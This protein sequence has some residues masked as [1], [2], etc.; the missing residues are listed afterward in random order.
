[1]KT[2]RRGRKNQKT[3]FRHGIYLYLARLK[4]VLDA[5]LETLA[6]NLHRRQYQ[7]ITDKVSGVADPLARFE[8]GNK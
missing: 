2:P 3:C 8:A 5:V 1:M 4:L 6:F 7:A